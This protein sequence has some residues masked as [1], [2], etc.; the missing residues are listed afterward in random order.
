MHASIAAQ[1]A[2]ARGSALRGLAVT[3]LKLFLRERAGPIWGLALPLILVIIFGS[4]PYFREP[5]R[6]LGGAAWIDAYVPVLIVFSLAMLS[7]GAMPGVL[8]GYRELGVLRRL[9]TTPA[10]PVRVLGAQ[11]AVNAAVAAAEV[12]A[13]LALARFGYGV[14]L[15][16]QAA[17]FAIATLLAAAALLAMGLLVAATAP[18]ARAAQSTGILLFYLMMFFAGLWLPLAEM[19]PLLRHISHAAPLGAAVQAL[20]DAAA[21]HWPHPL[22]LLTM[23]GYAVAFGLAAAKLFRWE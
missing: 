4:V 15:P 11:L 1:P 3:E 17:G 22:Q 18:T 19:P 10:G 16:R 7:L 5:R 9:Q 23:V 20:Q 21:G 8:A 2:A 13:I 6:V 14:E 12:I